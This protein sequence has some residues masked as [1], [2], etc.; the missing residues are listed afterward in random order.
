[1]AVVERGEEGETVKVN[2]ALFQG[3]ISFPMS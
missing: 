2:V 3:L 1:M